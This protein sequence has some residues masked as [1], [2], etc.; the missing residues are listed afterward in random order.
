MN[1]LAVTGHLG[2]DVTVRD[3]GKHR[4]ANFSLAVSDGYGEKKKTIW[5]NV[6]GWNKTAEIC[7]KYLSKGKKIIAEGRL[8]VR[9]YEDKNGVNRTS[10]E[11]IASRI[12]MIDKKEERR[13][14]VGQQYTGGTPDTPGLDDIPF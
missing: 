2:K 11:L 5:L 12:E 3:V 1:F 10:V 13:E 8:D 6:S 4:V 14:D 9:E 7:E